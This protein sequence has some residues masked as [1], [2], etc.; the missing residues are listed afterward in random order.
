MQYIISKLND[1]GGIS[2]I[3]MHREY[4]CVCFGRGGGGVCSTRDLGKWNA[5][6]DLYKF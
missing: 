5:I 4:V 2:C 1:H 6:Y 3:Q